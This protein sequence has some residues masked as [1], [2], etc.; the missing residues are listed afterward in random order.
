MSYSIKITL[1]NDFYELE[2]FSLCANHF[3]HAQSFFRATAS[4]YQQ[5]VHSFQRLCETEANRKVKSKAERQ[6]LAKYQILDLFQVD[7]RI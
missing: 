5:S 3:I 2:P 6:T 4:K 7:R 1:I